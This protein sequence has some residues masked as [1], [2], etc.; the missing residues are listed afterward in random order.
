MQQEIT[1]GV[2][3][4]AAVLYL[5]LSHRGPG[6][7]R[8][9]VKTAPVA[10]F[11]ALAWGAGAPGLLAGA[12]ALSAL[13]DLALSRA[14]ER[15][16]LAGLG[17][18]A[19]GHLCYLGL[20]AGAVGGVPLW[21][22]LALVGLAGSTELWLA[23]HTGALRQ[24]VRIYVILIC[25]MGIAAAG[26]PGAARLATLGAAL[27]LASDVILALQLFRMAPDTTAARAAGWAL[28]ALYICGQALI[29]FAFLPPPALS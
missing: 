19:L 16:F 28:W 5:P 25:A 10:L 1:V 17:A 8:S 15:A 3:L 4:A 7:L 18:F 27:F 11:A 14:G 23:P 29:L 9:A 13:G 21:P 12:L 24:P 6:A 26:L 20:F 2:A 22:A